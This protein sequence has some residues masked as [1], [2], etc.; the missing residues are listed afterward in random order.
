MGVSSTVGTR[1]HP[2]VAAVHHAR[3]ALVETA[4]SPLWSLSDAE[5]D[6]L[7][8]DTSA[9]L[10]AVTARRV[11]V[12]AEMLARG[13]MTRTGAATPTAF[14]RGRDRLTGPVA[15]RD[16]KVAGFVAGA[17]GD[18]LRAALWAGSVNADQ[19]GAIVAVLDHAPASAT[20]PVRRKAL[21][22]LVGYAAEHD[23]DTLRRLGVSI[24]A[25][26]DPDAA[27]ADEE[28]RLLAQERRARHRRG[29]VGLPDGDGG[30]RVRGNMPDADWAVVRSALSP[31]AAPRP[32][33]ADGPDTRTGAQRYVDALVE[34][35]RRQLA[36]GDLP[37][38][39]GD[40]PQIVLTTTIDALRDGDGHARLDDGTRLSTDAARRMVCGAIL[41]QVLL[42]KAGVPLSVGRRERLFKRGIRRALALR[43]RGCAF[44]GCDRPP[45]WCQAHHIIAWHDGGH[46]SL[47]NGVL[48]CGHH[49]RLIHQ[50]QWEVVMAHNGHPNF[51]PPPWIDPDR[52]PLRNHA[53]DALLN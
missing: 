15:A 52:K 46:T 41:V 19:A 28:A 3:E 51:L 29:I 16:A 4:E 33:P 48:L 50:R 44:P 35:A 45:A 38:D 17:D 8:A 18:P 27:D 9:V 37:D 13:T 30:T 10:S 26:L 12:H 31:L 5:L 6:Q 39:G 40:P 42:D 25:A 7:D 21:H 36:A 34:L 1:I 47:D 20:T 2:V 11:A 32:T 24:W 49:H 43:D 14:I 22:T 53:H 23:A